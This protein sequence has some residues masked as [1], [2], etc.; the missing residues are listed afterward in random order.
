MPRPKRSG[1]TPLADA[2][3]TLLKKQGIDQR[4][5]EYTAVEEWGRIVGKRI[6]AVTRA[7]RI[8]KGILTVEV[9]SAP[10]RQE[11]RFRKDEIL[12]KLN[13]HLGQQV[14]KDIRFH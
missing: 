6:S 3:D 14:V 8:Q 13:M 4:V 12:K 11:L 9:S 2:I 1:A 10:W 5:R 7:V